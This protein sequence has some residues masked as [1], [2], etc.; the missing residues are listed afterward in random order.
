MHNGG[1]RASGKFHS[2]PFY[3]REQPPRGWR[4]LS[5]WV[6]LEAVL[7]EELLFELHSFFFEAVFQ[8]VGDPVVS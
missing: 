5:W 2:F 8:N 7:L 4:G 1:I 6:L 3:A